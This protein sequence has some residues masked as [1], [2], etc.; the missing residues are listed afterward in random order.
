ME[1]N[2]IWCAGD[3][4][5]RSIGREPAKLFAPLAGHRRGARPNAERARETLR[6]SW[7]RVGGPARLCV[8]PAGRTPPHCVDYYLARG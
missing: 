3:E 7:P 8:G 1:L 6:R 4:Q 2:E 5:Q